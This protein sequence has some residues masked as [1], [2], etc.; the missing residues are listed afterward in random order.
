MRLKLSSKIKVIYQDLGSLVKIVS[1]V[2]CV[3]Y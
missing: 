1:E 2:L 3:V